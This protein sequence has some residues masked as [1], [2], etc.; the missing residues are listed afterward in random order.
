[1]ALGS[2]G[3]LAQESGTA[4][5]ETRTDGLFLHQSPEPRCCRTIWRYWETWQPEVFKLDSGQIVKADPFR[6]VIVP[7]G[8]DGKS[9][10]GPDG[11]PVIELKPAKGTEGSPLPP[12]PWRQ[13]DFDDSSWFRHEG[14]MVEGWRCLSLMCVRGKFEVQDP[15]KAPELT[16]SVGF[17]GGL[18]AYLNGKEVARAFM[19]EG[20]IAPETLAQPYPK[21]VYVTPAGMLI[22]ERSSMS[23]NYASYVVTSQGAAKIPPTAWGNNFKDPE[24]LARF[25]KRCRRL[26]VKIPASL[27]RKGT[28][29]LALEVHRA[30]A[31]EVMYKAIA[32]HK[33]VM[34]MLT[35]SWSVRTLFLGRVAPGLWW[36]HAALEDIRLSAAST[37][38][39][40]V[41]N[42]DRPK[43][44][45]VWNESTFKRVL[46][47]Q[48]GDPNEPLRPVVI[49]LVPN[50]AGSGQIVV[51]SSSAIKDLKVSVTDLKGAGGETIPASAVQACYALWTNY[52]GFYYG[53][54]GQYDALDSEAPS[55]VAVMDKAP[56]DRNQ[57]MGGLTGA[58]QPVWLIV[59]A[60]KTAKAG[61]YTGTVT[62]RAA[63]QKDVQTPLEVRVVSDYVLPDPSRFTTYVGMLESPD[64]VAMQYKLPLWSEE[65]WKLLDKAF[66]LLGQ[67]GNREVYIPLITKTMLGNEQSMVKWVKQADGSYKHDFSVAERYLDLAVKHHWNISVTCLGVSDGALGSALWYS[68]KPRNPPAVTVVDAAGKIGEMD[69]PAWGSP[70]AREFWKPVIDGLQALLQKRGLE[71]TMM[72]GF[73]VQNQVLPE[74]I[75]DLKALAPQAKW[76]EYTHW[77]KKRKGNDAN[78]QDVGRMAWAYGAPL[79]VFWNPDEDKPHYAWRDLASDVYFIA[80]PRAKGQISVG[81]TGELSIFRVFCEST[82]LGSHG[83]QDLI[84]EFR[85]FCGFS[86]VGADF[87]PVMPGADGK[88]LKRLDSRYVGWGSLSLTETI[89]SLLGTGKSAPSSSCRIQMLRESQQEAEA[90]VCV[91][92]ALLDSAQAAKL[93]EQAARFKQL[94]DERTK[95]FFY[96]TLYFGENGQEFGRVFNQEQWD[97]QTEKLYQAAAVASK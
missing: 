2:A 78:W 55:E 43:G 1:M 20:K 68:G 83:G 15:A 87:W 44:F 45:Q 80:A 42:V 39:G 79:A 46:P 77:S 36:N 70:Q 37:A 33:E 50:G 16:L 82:L 56:W 27:L 72:F 92:N 23:A 76:W 21:E 69:A 38:G 29:V 7:K 95:L 47:T 54:S 30:P 90:R 61:T 97:A 81:A 53:S 71:K 8:P 41:P 74:T 35:A 32:N 34:S 17:R 14:P 40:I 3:A 64:S 22:D 85:S 9:L 11:K 66:E 59:Q 52:G 84:P 19:P 75:G 91:T 57:S 67:V 13:A 58:V 6:T 86:M 5:L 51:G 12:E 93:G 89:Q 65:H 28:N 94:C 88:E 18:V 10:T 60:P 49:R 24:V 25:Q 63:G 62:V 31:N 26:E 73:V 4:I 96:D 48:Y